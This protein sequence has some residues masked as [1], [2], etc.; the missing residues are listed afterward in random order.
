MRKEYGQQ[1]AEN[2]ERNLSHPDDAKIPVD[3]AH[4]LS[5]GRHGCGRRCAQALFDRCDLP[6]RSQR[7]GKPNDDLKHCENNQ[8]PCHGQESTA[9]APEESSEAEPR[10][11][12]RDQEEATCRSAVKYSASSGDGTV[13]YLRFER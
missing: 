3:R 1:E 5:F 11:R 6:G 10:Q 9:R 13:R 4:A 2:N 8:R 12:Q 7:N